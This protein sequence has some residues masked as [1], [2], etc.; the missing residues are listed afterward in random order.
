MRAIQFR[1]YGD[2]SVLE[3]VDLPRPVP[4][5]GEVLVRVAATT[6]TPVDATLRAGHLQQAFPLRLPHVPGIDLAG[7]VE[8]V[9]PGVRGDLV[10]TAVVAFLPMSAPGAAAEHVLVPAELLAAAPTSTPLAD[11][12]VLPSS[13]LTAWQAL[14]EHAGLAQG[15]RLLVN[16][17]GGGV[18]RLAVQLA[19]SLGATV[20]ATAGPLSTAAVTAA[21]AAQVVDHT[22]TAVADA[23]TGPV[24][25]VLN[26]VRTSP[27]QNAALVALAAPGGAFVS[28]TSPGQDD[29]ERGV[30]ASSVFARSD[31]AQLAHLSSLVDAGTLRLDVGA[32][33]PLEQL[34]HVHA[35]AE[36]GQLHGRA[37][38]TVEG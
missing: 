14:V 38:I 17:A 5:P 2:P 26:L 21:G 35:L 9:G 13:G 3:L 7:T 12:A 18:G 19:A 10:G 30:R 20:I 27:A 24:D 1:S 8:E 4:G 31:A 16:G 15:Q 33:H 34:A 37:L 29:V 32:R 11:A 28:T 25:V 36:A 6:S 22:R 23:L